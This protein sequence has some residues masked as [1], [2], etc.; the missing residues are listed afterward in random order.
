MSQQTNDTKLLKITANKRG[1]EQGVVKK[2]DSLKHSQQETKDNKAEQETG[3]EKTAKTGK[4]EQGTCGNPGG[5]L[6]RRRGGAKQSLVFGTLIATA[7]PHTGSVFEEC[8][9]LTLGEG[10]CQ[11]WNSMSK[12]RVNFVTQ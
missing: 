1:K 2:A 8:V 9:Y 3:Q 6:L 4:Q 10:S 7:G 11:L 5:K 12:A